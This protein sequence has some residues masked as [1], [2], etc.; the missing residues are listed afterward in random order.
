MGKLVVHSAAHTHP[1][2]V[3]DVNED[4]FYA[5][6]GRGLWAVADGMGGYAAG[7]VASR[8]LVTSLERLELS[9][10]SFDIMVEEL[11]RTVQQVNYQLRFEMTLP[12]GCTQI[13]ST[14]VILFYHPAENKCACLWVGDSRVY[15]Q[16]NNELFQV[17]KDH[18]VVQEM[19]DN[20]VLEPSKRDT[21]PKSN[22]ITRAVGVC[23]ELAVD[24]VTFEPLSG[25]VYFLCSDGLYSELDADKMLACILRE[26]VSNRQGKIFCE[27]IAG[28]MLEEVL[29]TEAKD[30]VTVNVISVSPGQHA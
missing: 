5:D 1:G 21:H 9:E 8:L 20:G 24:V 22:V 19:V 6:C 10:T 17:T 11:E 3:R 18:S 25:D 15:V 30:N 16:R 29:Q 26:D 12:H 2:H 13:G 4:A 28:R 23:D 14:I 27:G 7:D